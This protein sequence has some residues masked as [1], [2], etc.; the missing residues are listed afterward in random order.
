MASGTVKGITIE[1]LGKTDGLVKSL[2]AVNKELSQTQKNLKTVEQALKLDPKNVDTL[3]QK[4]SLLNDAI[5]QTQEKLKLEKQA[6]E[7]AAKALEE[8]TITKSQYDTMTTEIQ[9]TTAELKDL[10]SQAKQTDA[11]I[12]DLGGSNSMASFQDALGKAQ[13][14]LK[15]VGDS[16]ADVGEKLTKTATAA[17]G[18]FGAI[19]VKTFYDVDDA[20]D[21]VAKKTG[22]T[23]EE[24][25]KMEDIASGIATSIPTE[26]ETAAAAVGEVSTKFGV[27]GDSLEYLSTQFVK[28]ADLNDTDVSSSIDK[29]QKALAA[30]GKDSKSAGTLLNVLN[31]TAQNTGVSVDKLEDGLVQNGVAF[32][33]MGLSMWQAVDFMGQLEKSGA[34]SETVMQGMRKAL[35]N[36]TKEGKDMSTALYELQD[37]ILNGTSD[38]DGLTYAYDLFGKSGDQIYG[39]LKNG[40]L[41]FRDVANSAIVLADATDS[42]T[43]TYTNLEDGSG[44]LKVATNNMKDALKEVGKTIS[45]SLSPI[46]KKCSEK[47]KEFAQWW[48]NLDPNVQQ[49]IL[50][51]GLFIGVLGPV[52]LIV[53]KVVGGISKLIG[54][55]KLLAGFITGTVIPALTGTG[56][57]LTATLAPIAAV[58]AAITAVILVMKNWDAIIEVLEYAWD[59]LCQFILGIVTTLTEAWNDFQEFM[60][61]LI[62]SFVEF[63]S[64]AWEDIKQFFSDIWDGIKQIA[65]DAWEAITG[66]FEGIG[67][68][69]SDRFQEAYDAICDIFGML[70][71]FFSGVWDDIVS[72]FT[73]VGTA[74]GD[75]VSGAV[76][77]VINSVLSGAIGIINGFISLI[78]GAIKIINKIP[79]VNIPRIGKLD[80]VQLEQGGIL[81]K[82]EIGLLEGNG[83]EAVVPLDQNKKWISAVANQ[84]KISL[85]AVKGSTPDYTPQLN[86]ILAAM[87]SGATIVI[88]QN[89]NG[90]AFDRQVIQAVNRYNYKTGGR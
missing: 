29:V 54:V 70:G 7:E 19:S 47:L 16:I 9:K 48:K 33:E 10:E 84:M 58:V 21:I 35:K 63:W 43:D 90:Q 39:A 12:K 4:Q 65:S 81:K 55:F 31:K 32:E 71:E 73:E 59:Q 14:K 78:N 77:N 72:I 25:E 53:G 3:K 6:A 86:A 74:V 85:D 62:E 30:Y 42:V 49:I 88:N 64:Q 87:E 76:K 13:E 18:A 26:F 80:V 52:I 79:G 23:G 1:I 67:Q 82:G 40:S 57:T 50:K 5:K 68:W 69:F 38:M 24:L 66:F 11:Q 61:E 20:L 28:F 27:T 22:A 34:N 17:V 83:A 41:D 15:A 89:M 46:I 8:G 45:E 36:A 56:A 51:I 2:G 44:E 75:A 60:T 37:A